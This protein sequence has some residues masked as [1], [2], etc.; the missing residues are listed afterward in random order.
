ML[1]FAFRNIASLEIHFE[2]RIRNSA[3]FRSQT[4]P[5]VRNHAG[6]GKAHC[7][8]L[9]GIRSEKLARV[10]HQFPVF[11]LNFD[12]VSFFRRNHGTP[13]GIFARRS[14]QSSVIRRK[15]VAVPVGNKSEHGNRKQRHQ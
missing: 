5:L 15:R 10:N 4:R 1:I 2:L 8:F 7:D 14:F 12:K 9:F 3:H 11:D 13:A 6:N